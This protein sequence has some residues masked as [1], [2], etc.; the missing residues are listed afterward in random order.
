MWHY[1]Y[2][3]LPVPIKGLTQSCKREHDLCVC[4]IRQESTASEAVSSASSRETT[5]L[6]VVSPTTLNA[7]SASGSDVTSGSHVTEDSSAAPRRL[8][9]VQ[10]SFRHSSESVS[11]HGITSQSAL[12]LRVADDGRTGENAAEARAEESG[13]LN[14]LPLPDIADPTASSPRDS[15]LQPAPASN[16]I[17]PAVDHVPGHDDDENVD[18]MASLTVV[19]ERV[20]RQSTASIAPL[21]LASSDNVEE[22]GDLDTGGNHN[23][24]ATL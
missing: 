2:R 19:A 11:G 16:V 22:L 21:I 1:N 6:D 8:Y 17:G 13:S 10:Q 5:Q 18:D 3:P 23:S 4:V 14:V 20:V 9:T 24:T 12:P 15:A 7:H